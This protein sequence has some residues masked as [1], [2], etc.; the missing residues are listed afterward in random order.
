MAESL[1]DMTK[2]EYKKAFDTFDSN[3]DGLI[4]EDDLLKLMNYLKFYP[5]QIELAS[6]IE[7]FT[8]GKKAEITFH[9]FLGIVSAKM[10][11]ENAEN[12]LMQAFKIFDVEG[13]GKISALSLKKSLLELDK[14]LTEE[15]LHG[16]LRDMRDEDGQINYTKLVKEFLFA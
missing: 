9:E 12:D 7:E 16:L 5:N 3:K 10:F 14:D 11:D 2:A 13:R 15:E 8:Q 1:S 4:T 6:I